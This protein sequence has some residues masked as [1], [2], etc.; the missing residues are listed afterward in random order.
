MSIDISKLSVSDYAA[1]WGA[2][3][4]TLALLWN[5]I[6]ALRSGARIKVSAVP[7][8]SVLPRQPITEDNLYISVTAVNHGGS[9]TTITHFCGYSVSGFWSRIRGKKQLFVINT[10]PALGK[11]I[12]CV[13][14]PGE[15]WNSLADQ[16]SLIKNH[17][18]CN[19]YL[20]I[21]H[22]QS[23]KPVYVRVRINA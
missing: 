6:T 18:K 5:I 10:H 1:W 8:M 23:K 12:P 7:N 17:P 16:K 13:L 4:A 21:L 15:E 14:A 20:G 22:N 2:I 11:K 19:L 9:S 3:I